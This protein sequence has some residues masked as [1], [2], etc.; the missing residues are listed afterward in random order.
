[1]WRNYHTVTSIDRAL[2]LLQQ[3]GP[4]ARLIAGGT[5]I[6]IE[7]ERN[8]RPDVDI[9]IDVTRVVGLDRISRDQAGTI[10]M[11]PLVTHNQCVA[12]TV[13]RTNAWPLA[14]ACWEVGAPQIR[15]RSTVAGNLI[16]ASPA[17]DTITPLIAMGATVTLRS[18]SG[19][20]RVPLSEFYLGVRQT[21]MR[22]NEML[23]EISVPMLGRHEM[24]TFVKL[25]LR[26]AQAIAVVNVTAIAQIAD[27]EDGVVCARVR[28]A[29]GAVAPTI[30]RALA[31]ERFLEGRLLD[32]AAIERAA[33]LA[34][35]AA[36]PIDDLRGS[37][38][39]RSK[40]VQV[41]TRRALCAIQSRDTS[42]EF[43]KHPALLGCAADGL[44]EDSVVADWST[45][46]SGSGEPI[47]TMVNGREYTV[48]DANHKNLLR[49]L[50]EDLGLIGTKE[51]CSE[52]ECGACTVHLDG[53]AVMSCL[54]PAPRG[55]RANITT[56]EGLADNEQLHPLQ[57]AFIDAGAVQCGYCTPGLL[58]AGAKFLDE[59]P[60]PTRQEV[61]HAITGNLCRCTGYYKVFAAIE[62]ASAVMSERDNL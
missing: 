31:A 35:D 59:R 2:E 48:R 7:L 9:L 23:T 58:M 14:Q 25:G 15:N 10:R 21:V 43:P 8:L 55:H 37:A 1:M 42:G 28:I 27:T 5:D 54:V 12:S 49:M 26:R 17:N 6:L 34:A 30:V 47:V 38:E 60:H 3:H 39:Y 18:V 11:G 41:I 45:A 29:M 50:R 20:R 56:V 52:G 19:E 61:E 24:G 53:A 32:R 16:T 62:Q 46:E 22:P 4:R 57:Q 40:M 51:G 13:I 33:E 44:Y 36:R